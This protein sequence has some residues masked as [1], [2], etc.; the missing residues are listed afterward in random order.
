M[1]WNTLFVGGP[2]D[3]KTEEDVKQLHRQ[4]TVVCCDD[5]GKVVSA[6]Y[7]LEDDDRRPK[8]VGPDTID[9]PENGVPFESEHRYLFVGIERKTT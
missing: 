7:V 6:L 8:I 2:A 5:T 9:D 4:R 1:I 3:G